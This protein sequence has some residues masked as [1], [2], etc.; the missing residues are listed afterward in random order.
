MIYK[1]GDDLRQDY[2]TLQLITIMERIW[3]DNG[4]NMC[5]KPYKAVPTGD[6]QGMLQV[7]VNSDTISNIQ[8]AAGGCMGAFKTDP[9][10]NWLDENRPAAVSEEEQIHNFVYS[11]AGYCVATYVLGIGDRHNDNIMVTKSGN[12]FHIDFGHFLGN[13]KKKFGVKRERAPFV[14]TPDLAYVMGGKDSANFKKF[15]ELTCQSYILLRQNANLFI[16]LFSMMIS[17]GMPELTKEE[18][19]QYLQEAFALDLSDAEAESKMKKLIAESLDS[20]ATKVNFAI[21]I[22]AH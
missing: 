8:K 10:K 19:I 12:F 3:Q 20:T 7:V 5:M 18:D 1:A 15:V 16:T 17:S 6:E 9:I 4:L 14:F 21:H 2:L 22:L 11:C 13:I